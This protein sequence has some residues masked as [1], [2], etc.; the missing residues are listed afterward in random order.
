MLRRGRLVRTERTLALPTR[1]GQVLDAHITDGLTRDRDSSNSDEAGQE[2]TWHGC[3][4]CQGQIACA[5]CRAGSRNL[6]AHAQVKAADASVIV[7]AFATWHVKHDSARR[8][9]E[10]GVRLIDHCAI[11]SYSMLTRLPPPYRAPANVVQ[12][13]LRDQFPDAYLRLG[14]KAH[15]RF[16]LGLQPKASL[17]AQCMMHL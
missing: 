3:R 1:T 6:G 14:A 13:F 4:S 5:K 7:A 10:E 9:I 11:E 8:A 17:V 2:R 16:I 12:E 15:R